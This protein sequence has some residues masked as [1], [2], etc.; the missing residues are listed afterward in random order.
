MT[1]DEARAFLDSATPD[2]MRTGLMFL[3]G[4]DPDGFAAVMEMIRHQREWG[5]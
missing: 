1:F 5:P 2:E 4:Y 3:G